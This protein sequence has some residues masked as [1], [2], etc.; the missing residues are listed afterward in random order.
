MAT[1]S[2]RADGASGSN[3]TCV[4]EMDG[5]RIA[6]DANVLLEDVSFNLQPGN[7]CVLT[8]PNGSGK[9]SLLRAGLGLAPD[10]IA[11][12]T[13][14]SNFRS[15]AYVPQFQRVDRQ[16]PCSIANM[17]RMSFP[18]LHYLWSPS[19]RT[20]REDRIQ[21]ILERVGLM[22]RRD[23]LLRECSGGE[24]QRAML[25]RALVGEPDL[26]VLD[27]ATA[28]LDAEGTADFFELMRDIR[29][30]GRLCIWAISHQADAW[31][32]L[33]THRMT[34]TSEARLRFAPIGKAEAKGEASE[35]GDA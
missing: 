16:F 25:A 23:Q 1:D 30:D 32:G 9:S 8:G 20:A 17:L 18:G 26:L 13:L 29:A 31:R 5:V 10:S 4:L 15:P 19:A 14:R 27:E 35:R 7:V 12:G 2:A 34:I 24:L 3:S 28:S 11:G 33:A 22:H 21:E 6:Y